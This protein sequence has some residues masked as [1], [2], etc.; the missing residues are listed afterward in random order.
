M[1][2]SLCY[3]N[4]ESRD[5][6]VRHTNIDH[7]PQRLLTPRKFYLLCATASLRFFILNINTHDTI[8]RSQF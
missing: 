2:S 7:L 6:L 1:A 5:S 8:Q 3:V 4:P